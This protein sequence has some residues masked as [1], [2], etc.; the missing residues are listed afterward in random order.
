[1]TARKLVVILL[2][3]QLLVFC[4]VTFR[5]YSLTPPGHI[6]LPT[7]KSFLYPTFFSP[8]QILQAKDGAWGIKDTHTT[9][10]QGR[11][12]AVWYFVLSGKI[13]KLFALSPTTM[14]IA[15]EI[16][17]GIAVFFAAYILVA[18]LLPGKYQLL[19]LL[20]AFIIE[21]GP[22]FDS[23]LQFPQ[24]KILVPA[25]DA[26]T[27]LFRFFALPHHGL[28]DALGLL[29]LAFLVRSFNSQTIKNFVI[30]FITT[31]L[32]VFFLPPVVITLGLSVY[33]V[34][35]LW[36]VITKTFKRLL[37]A[38]I[39]A[40]VVVTV[41][42]IQTKIAFTNAGFPWDS[43]TAIEKSW[44]NNT[45]AWN[46]Y[47]SSLLSYIPFCILLVVV[48]PF[49]W[50]YWTKQLRLSVLLLFGWV[51]MPLVYIPVSN[52][53]FFPVANM[54]LIDGSLYIAAGFLSAIALIE[55][56]T[57]IPNEKIKRGVF[58]VII[59]LTIG[60]SCFVTWTYDYPFL[61]YQQQLDPHAYPATTTWGGIQYMQK[62]PRESGVMVREYF[63]EI[64]PG[65]ANVRVYIGGQHGFP[66]WLERQANAITFFS[67]TLP[68]SE[69]KQFLK[70]NDIQYVFYGPDEQ[71][72][73]TKSPLY[74]DILKPVFNNDSVTIFSL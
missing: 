33:P 25:N 62:L 14:Y 19:G 28:G 22:R 24:T 73:T 67:G 56:I 50:R 68:E 44:W 18:T 21:L 64:L 49:R 52:Y 3:Y 16:F 70:T 38:L 54:R 41:A 9:R 4:F 63:G 6:Y 45:D 2:A 36:S 61:K 5:P 69:A 35:I 48:F 66:D 46:Q 10:P 11:A 7:S 42:G 43:W 65:F 72:V 47:A 31:I 59:G 58:S 20:F 1:M 57:V 39:I 51:L 15:G 29:S 53:P 12:F 60:I 26:F 13:A 32:S 40:V 23:L 17:G 8:N 74:P 71:S 27:Q 37:P 34:L 30:L 55:S